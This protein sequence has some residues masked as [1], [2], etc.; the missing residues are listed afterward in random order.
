VTQTPPV[1]SRT[2]AGDPIFAR[3]RLA[4]V[5]ATGLLDTGPEAAFDD[6]TRLA[7]LLISAPF[8][9]AT[10]LDDRR[11]Y[12]KSSFGLPEGAPSE[13]SIDES[14]CQYVVRSRN[15][16]IVANAVQ[17]ERT[18]GN[19]SIERLGVLAWAGFPLVAP[20]GE[21]LGS[22]CVVDTRP[23][24]WTERDL[25][26]LRTLAGAASR[27]IALRSAIANEREL[28]RRAESLTHTLQASLLPPALPP[29]AGLDVA[30][31]FHPAGTGIEL[32]GDFY[33]L[34]RSRQGSWSFVVGDV[35]GKGIEAAKAASLARHTVGVAA[36]QMNDPSSVLNVLNRTIIARRENPDLFLTALYGVLLVGPAGCDLRLGSAGHPAPILRRANGATETVAVAGPLIGVFPSLDID[37]VRLHLD[38]GDALIAYTDGVSESRAGRALFGEE[39]ICE[40]VARADPSDDA[41]TLAMRIESTALAF[42]GGVASDD[43]AILVLRVPPS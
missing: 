21:V 23:R 39:A 28:R 34:F 6:L 10:I 20:D 31:R 14:F 38:P 11:S 4:A 5:A 30:G 36:T 15:E 19:P 8:A 3:A 1:Q 33:D 27:E 40:I 18:Q 24:E 25:D 22:F 2:D 32:V 29:I 16:L 17:D 41:A 42:G 12:W 13:N 7:A 37:E 26:V 35:C 9:F 43:I